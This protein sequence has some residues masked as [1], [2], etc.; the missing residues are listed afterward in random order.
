MGSYD[1]CLPCSGGGHFS[2]TVRNCGN[3]VC[4]VGSATETQSEEQCR[5]ILEKGT[6]IEQ[7]F[8]EYFT[9]ESSCIDKIPT[10]EYN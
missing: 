2:I 3:H 10:E 6:R 1:T 5:A 9:G 8:A 7:E 4:F